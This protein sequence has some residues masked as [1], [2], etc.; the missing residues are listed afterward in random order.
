[1][2]ND[3]RYFMGVDPLSL[4][5]RPELGGRMVLTWRGVEVRVISG[6]AAGS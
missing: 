6:D 5:Q 4:P 1:M 3:D 2:S